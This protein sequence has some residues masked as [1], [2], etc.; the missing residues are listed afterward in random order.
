MHSVLAWGIGAAYISYK[1]G[2]K[3]KMLPLP[4]RYIALT[5]FI[6]ISALIGAFNATAGGL[7]AYGTLFGIFLTQYNQQTKCDSIG[8]AGT[9]PGQA[10]NAPQQATH[11]N[12]P[13]SNADIHMVSPYG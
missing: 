6:S 10:G 8:N 3:C 7:I 4:K 13:G 11:G 9:Q 12:V 5:G 2:Y 1:Y